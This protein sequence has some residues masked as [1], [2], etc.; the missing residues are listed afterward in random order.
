MKQKFRPQC[1]DPVNGSDLCYRVFG[2]NGASR[3]KEFKAFFAC[4]D[5]LIPTPPTS[6]HPNWKIQPLLNHILRVS[7]DAMFVGANISVD[8]QDI[9]FQ[10]QHA[11]KMRISY[12]KVGDG[13][14]VDA[15]CADGY[16]YCFYFRNQ[17]A[18]KKWMD[19]GLS[20]LHSRVM[21][22]FSQLKKGTNHYKCYMDNLFM[23]AKFAKFAKCAQ[24]PSVL[25]H[26]VTRSSG[27]GIPACLEQKI[28]NK[29]DDLLSTRGTLKVAKLVGDPDCQLVAASLYDSKP[30]Y[31]LSA[32]AETVEWKKKDRKLYHKELGKKVSSPFY[33]LNLIDDYNKHM[34]NVDI[35]DQLRLQYRVHRWI[36]NRKWWWPIF[37]WGFETLLT[38]SFI[39]Y[40]KFQ[41]MHGRKPMSHY[42]YIRMIALAW[43]DKEEYW[44]RLPT[45]RTKRGR[46]S[47]NDGSSRASSRAHS[48]TASSSSSAATAEVVTTRSSSKR[49]KKANDE[50]TR[51][52]SDASLDPKKGSLCIRLD[53]NKDHFPE[54][55]TSKNSKCQ[56]HHWLSKD[57]VRS[58]LMRCNTCHVTLCLNCFKSFHVCENLTELKPM[59]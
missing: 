50:R 23:S 29:K 31:L 35:A 54:Q 53:R 10:G 19:K 42:D 3:H 12:K 34:G 40:R 16:T 47:D 58:Q 52:F 28:V 2:I 55:V 25:I 20:P 14:L 17:K 24:N 38:N 45:V 8:E 59:F 9:G 22:L 48:S 27:R 39:L 51:K 1:E 26:G 6:T 5:P 46:N 43:I 13:F 56:L 36:R 15:L 44:Y 57:R 30:V 41:E 49:T 33:R 7:K 11:D 4:V 32:S 21:A 18:P 37:F